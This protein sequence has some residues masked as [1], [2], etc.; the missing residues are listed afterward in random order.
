MINTFICVVKFNQSEIIYKKKIFADY[1]ILFLTLI[2]Y[3]NLLKRTLF[4][5][6]NMSYFNTIFKINYIL[7]HT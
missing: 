1:I 2:Q 4:S 3:Y 7:K 6:L 5:L